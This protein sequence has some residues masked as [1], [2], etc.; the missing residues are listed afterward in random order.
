[1][2]LPCFANLSTALSMEFPKL[3]SCSG[4][5]LPAFCQEV[6]NLAW[7]FPRLFPSTHLP[8]L[9]GGCLCLKAQG[10]EKS[11]YSHLPSWFQNQG[12]D[13]PFQVLLT[14]RGCSR[15][16][17]PI[18]TPYPST[19]T[20][21]QLGTSTS[22]SVGPHVALRCRGT[23]QQSGDPRCQP[24]PLFSL[25]FQPGCEADWVGESLKDPLSYIFQPLKVTHSP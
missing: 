5:F 7:V 4:V 3:T 19:G 17:Y 24:P 25:S 2:N 6:R 10:Q 14:L 15:C 22:Y 12:S 16:H 9:S 20:A 8:P 18:T 13:Y 11:A 21:L 1:M 23:M